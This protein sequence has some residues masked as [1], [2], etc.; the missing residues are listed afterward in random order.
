MIYGKNRVNNEIDNID[1]DKDEDAKRYATKYINIVNDKLILINAASDS[2]DEL[3]EGFDVDTSN[4]IA[5]KKLKDF[6]I[7][8]IKSV[9]KFNLYIKQDK[10][11]KVL[12]REISK[13][14]MSKRKISKRKVSKRKISKRKILIIASN[15]LLKLIN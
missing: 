9:N 13:R 15:I 6:K 2:I 1:C 5:I 7:I 8:L 12:R 3:M 11:I 4:D 14:K 10:K